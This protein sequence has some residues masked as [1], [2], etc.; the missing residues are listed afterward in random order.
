[1][2]VK[3]IKV[4]KNKFELKLI[5]NIQVFFK[6]CQFLFIIYLRFQKNSNFIYLYICQGLKKINSI[7]VNR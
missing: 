5:Y 6:L 1:M 3:K 2:K 7:W 4:I